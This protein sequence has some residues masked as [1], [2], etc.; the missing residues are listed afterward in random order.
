MAAPLLT[1]SNIKLTFGGDP[2]LDG[3]SLMVHERDRIALVGRNGSGKST[4]LKVAAGLVEQDAGL[5]TLNSGATA[6]YLM[7]EPDLSGFENVGAYVTDALTDAH[8]IAAA[9]RTMEALQIDPTAAPVALSGGETR[10]AAIAKLFA[11]EPDILLL[12]EPTNHLDLPAI[13]WL[14]ENLRSTRSAMVVISHDRAFLE[15]ITT[16]TVWI[17]RGDTRTLNKGF[18]AFEAWRDELLEEEARNA[19]KLD[20]KIAAEED[21]VRYGVTAR[22]KR[23]VRRLKEL[24]NLRQ[25]KQEARKVQ[26]SVSFSVAEGANAGKQVIIADNISKSF[27]DKKIVDGFS[28]KIARGDR[29]G[30][31]GPNGAGKTT[32]LKLLTG[33]LAPD[34]GTITLGANLQIL[35]LDQRRESLTDDMRVADAITDGRGDWV[36][37]GEQKKHVS[38][39]LKDFLFTEEQWRTPVGALSGGERGR[40]ALA[41]ALAK[42]SNL[43]ILD[44]P[45][46]DLDLE[47]LELLEE[48]LSDYPGTLLLVSHDRRF[49]DRLVTSVITTDPSEKPGGWLEYA[50]GYEDMLAQRG[51]APGSKAKLAKPRTSDK[52]NEKKA[53]PKNSTAK[54]SYKEKYALE[55]LPKEIAT[56]EEKINASTASLE[57]P[58]LFEKDPERFEATA[59]ALEKDSLRLEKAEEEWLAL[60]MKREEIEG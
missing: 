2:L 56:L 50:G 21:W 19:H 32:L 33:L 49:L 6:G 13:S 41:A 42:P 54:L 10:R 34:E 47:T 58:A 18:G 1:L 57:D 30:L 39:Y 59:K 29:I 60:E 52:N 22:R 45:T 3:A 40:L 31:V 28:I 12:D 11:L 37:I 7:Q 25:Q 17:D 48:T 27:G 53:Q 44:E 38:T 36:T 43:L 20:R 46:N 55:Q 4:L 15:A 26:G 16:Q 24:S 23:N 35:T 5:R 8:E 9:R 51:K 14:E